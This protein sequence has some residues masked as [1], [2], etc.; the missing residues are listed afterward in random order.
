MPIRNNHALRWNMKL[1]NYNN[2]RNTSFPNEQQIDSSKVLPKQYR[3]L[4]NFVIKHWKVRTVDS[5]T[6]QVWM[7]GT[8][9]KVSTKYGKI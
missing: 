6:Y 2:N 4:Q 3:E 8:A 7:G 1:P 9:P 5:G